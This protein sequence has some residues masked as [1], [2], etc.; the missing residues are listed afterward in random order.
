MCKGQIK[1]VQISLNGFYGF[2][3]FHCNKLLLKPYPLNQRPLRGLYVHVLNSLTSWF[4][5]NVSA[6]KLAHFWDL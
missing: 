5:A 3:M 1:T 4:H 6:I 2:A